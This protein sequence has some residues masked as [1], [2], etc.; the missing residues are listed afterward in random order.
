MKFKEFNFN[1]YFEDIKRI[2]KSAN[3][4]AYLQ[5][6]EK[7]KTAFEKSLYLL[8]AFEKNRLVGFIRCVGDG[9]HIVLIQ[10]LIVDPDFYRQKIGTKLFNF[11]AEKYSNVR[12]LCLFTDIYD[13]RDNEFYKSI[14]LVKIEEKNM[15]SYIR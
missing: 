13:I 11:I 3:W 9:E 10:D 1:D 15:V 8:G 4:N 2:F 6:D 7:L 14:G 12:S 5:D